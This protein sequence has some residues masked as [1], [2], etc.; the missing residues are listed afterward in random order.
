MS[1]GHDAH[2]EH[3]NTGHVMF[4]SSQ[5]KFEVWNFAKI[6]L[7]LKQKGQATV[8]TEWVTVR[9]LL[10]TASVSHCMFN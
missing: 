3:T 6:T 8:V 9:G 7:F 10:S 2:T 1:Q 5:V 4:L